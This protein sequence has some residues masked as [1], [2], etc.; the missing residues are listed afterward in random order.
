MT[1]FADTGARGSVRPGV[2]AGHGR[3]AALVLSA[4]AARL[5]LRPLPVGSP[6]PPPTE[7][8]P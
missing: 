6:N 1:L 8:D 4:V 7:T 5:M 2:A 3:L